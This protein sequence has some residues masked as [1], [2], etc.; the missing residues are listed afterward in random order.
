MSTGQRPPLPRGLLVGGLLVALLLLA[1][2]VIGILT[3]L[4]VGRLFPTTRPA[5]RIA[6]TPS[7]VR[8]VQG[9]NQL[10]SVRYVLEKVVIF[11]DV[12]WY[13]ENRLLMIA[14]GVAHAGVDLSR[15]QPGDIEVDGTRVRLSLPPPQMLDVHL[16][17]RRTRVVER[18]TGVL[19]EYDKDLEQEAR[20]QAV[21]QI[22]LAARDAG[23]LRDAETRAAAQLRDFLGALGFTEVEIRTRHASVPLPG[24]DVPSP[25]R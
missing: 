1:S 16:D 6:D 23:I 19:R 15:M 9:L 2:V 24:T 17:D 25:L 20:R 7:L 3:G 11:E 14:H 21:D 5:P 18:S 10:V 13:G 8:Q 22:K 12:K 4:L